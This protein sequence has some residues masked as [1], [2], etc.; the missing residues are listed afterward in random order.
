MNRWQKTEKQTVKK[1]SIQKVEN[2]SAASVQNAPD[3][4]LRYSSPIYS[5]SPL[6]S[7]FRISHRNTYSSNVSSGVID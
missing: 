2:A 1:A 5:K 6:P 7:N 4:K 3:K